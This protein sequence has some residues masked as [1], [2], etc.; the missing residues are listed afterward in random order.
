MVSYEKRYGRYYIRPQANLDYVSLMEGAYTE[1][2]GGDG[3]DLSVKSRTSSRLAAFAGVAVGATYGP[4]NSW[5]P[6]VLIGY[7]GVA[8]ENLGATTARFVA[9][10]DAFTLRSEDL[11]GQGASAHIA[12]KGE[13]GSGGFAMETGAEARDGLTIYDL[14]LAGHVQF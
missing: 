5:G 13:N 9:G 2:G 6:E 1:S 14:K 4:D 7:K 12:L 8:T 3:M 11:S 10:G